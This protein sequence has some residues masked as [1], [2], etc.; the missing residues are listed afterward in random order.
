MTKLPEIQSEKYNNMDYEEIDK[1]REK[2]ASGKIELLLND[3]QLFLYLN[4][5]N[6]GYSFKLRMIQNISVIGFVAMFIVLFLDWRISPIIFIVAIISQIYSRK[7]AKQYIYKQCSEDRVFLKF[8][9]AVGLV[10]LK[11][12]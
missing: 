12:Q 9:L 2:I 5:M 8:A 6:K 7:L 11:D 3:A 10:R 4:Q 1:I